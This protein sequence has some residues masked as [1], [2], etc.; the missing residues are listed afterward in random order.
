MTLQTMVFPTLLCAT[1]IR[2]NASVGSIEQRNDAVLLGICI[3]MLHIAKYFCCK[4][5]VAASF[6]AC[7]EC[8]FNTPND[9]H[10]SFRIAATSSAKL[11]V[12]PSTVITEAEMPFCSCVF[13]SSSVTSAPN[14]VR[15]NC[16]IH[17]LSTPPWESQ[18]PFP[19]P[20]ALIILS[21][22]SSNLAARMVISISKF[23]DQYCFEHPSI[24]IHTLSTSLAA[25]SLDQP[26]R[27]VLVIE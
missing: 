7:F 4:I 6:L 24:K 2:I 10:G 14:T 22:V 17:V 21:H 20:G 19:W 13:Q 11:T 25:I 8:P 3:A 26:T 12:F 23:P 16:Q 15:K 1:K 5:T 27:R 9:Q 18:S